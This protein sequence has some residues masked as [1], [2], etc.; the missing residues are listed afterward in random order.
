MTLSTLG[1]I[2]GLTALSNIVFKTYLTEYHSGFRAFS[3]HVLENIN[4]KVNKNNFVFDFE[5][6]AQIIAKKYKIEEIPIQTRYFD[7]SS[8]IKFISA[9]IYGIGILFNLFKYFLYKRFGVKFKQFK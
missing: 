1:W 3:K 9:V 2:V 7:E 4:I 6:I 5:I 8:S